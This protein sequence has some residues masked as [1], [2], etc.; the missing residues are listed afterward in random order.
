[1]CNGVPNL[2]VTFTVTSG[3][4]KV[5]GQDSVTINT[6]ITGHSAVNF[7]LGPEAGMNSVEANYAGNPNSPATFIAYGVVC[8]PTKPTTFTGLVMDNSSQPVGGALC[9][10]TVSGTTFTTT[11]DVQGCFAFEPS[12]LNPPHRPR[13]TLRRWHSG[14][15]A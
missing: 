10:L 8:D 12:T 15:I 2:P 1:M 5:N 3:G 11:T 13:Q 9:K 14:Y 6:G 7:T 4:G